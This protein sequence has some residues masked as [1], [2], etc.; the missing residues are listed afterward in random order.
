ML[1]MILYINS[2]VWGIIGLIIGVPFVL[3]MGLSAL[4]TIFSCCAAII[5]G[6]RK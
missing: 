5:K 2:W 3:M 1:E 4:V 6:V